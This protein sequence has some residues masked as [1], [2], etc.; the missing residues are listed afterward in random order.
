MTDEEYVAYVASLTV[1]VG[2]GLRGDAALEKAAELGGGTY[3]RAQ[4]ESFADELRLNPER[5]AALERLVDE[6]MREL[7][8]GQ[9]PG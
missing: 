1:A 5:W 9:D 3:T 4:V 6:R 2:E 7:A 8:R